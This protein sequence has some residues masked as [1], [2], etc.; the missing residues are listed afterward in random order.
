MPSANCSAPSPSREGWGGDP[1]ALARGSLA[2]LLVALG[3]AQ[4]AAADSVSGGTVRLPLGPDLAATL[5]R[6]GVKLSP[7]G[8]AQLHGRNLAL[9]VSAGELDVGVGRL[10]LRGGLKLTAGARS[11]SIGQIVLDTGSGAMTVKLGG[12][13][14]RL[15]LARRPRIDRDGFGYRATL[16]KLVLT[17]S[18]ARRLDDSL[19]L[20]GLL[21]AGDVLGTASAGIRFEQLTV[22]YGTAYL[23]LEEAFGAKLRSLAVEV[24][25]GGAGWYFSR[26][27]LSLAL[28]D[29]HGS[30]AL[31][32]SAGSLVSPD[33]LRLVQ[34]ASAGGRGHSVSR[35]RGRPWAPRA[36]P[37]IPVLAFTEASTA[38]RLDAVTMLGRSGR[39]G[40]P[41]SHAGEPL[42]HRALST[43][44]EV[45]AVAERGRPT[46]PNCASGSRR[47]R[48]WPSAGRCARPSSP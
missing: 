10:S 13:A 19:A 21:G 12:R 8:P 16:G 40:Q 25:P 45:G 46:E 30:A 34:A 3:T 29:M 43:P 31:D 22:T 20:P 42:G 2:C 9:P 32:F 27:P 5:H 11:A 15:A 41:P 33:G 7:L 47:C 4:S 6:A 1:R 44:R 14:V 35:P 18:G 36:L 37:V 38:P 23:G 24:E 17:G 39:S 28:T 48:A 26:T